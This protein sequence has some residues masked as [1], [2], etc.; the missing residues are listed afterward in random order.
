[1]IHYDF[2]MCLIYISQRSAA[3]KLMETYLGN[4][5]QKTMT[6]NGIAG[7]IPSYHARNKLILAV[8]NL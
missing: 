7:E 8:A 1:M 6:S 4:Q 3:S 5:L 2:L